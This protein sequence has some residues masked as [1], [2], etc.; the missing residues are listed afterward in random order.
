MKTLIR[1]LAAAV[2]ALGMTQAAQAAYP[3]KPVRIVKVTIE[4]T[5][6]KSTAAATCNSSWTCCPI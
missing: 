4:K 5:V 1:F 6:A 2:A 3:E